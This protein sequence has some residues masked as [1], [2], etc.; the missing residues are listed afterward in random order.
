MP[1]LPGSN[2]SRRYSDMSASDELAAFLDS[3]FYEPLLAEGKFTSFKRIHDRDLQLKGV[4]V[5]LSTADLTVSI[6]EKAQLYYINKD[7]PTFAFELQFLNNGQPCTGWFLNETLLTNYYLL[8]WPKARVA[9]A[10]SVRKDDFI[11]LDAL[12]VSRKKLH[13]FLA[14]NGLS[15]KVLEAEADLLRSHALEYDPEERK[16]RT[17]L[18]GAYYYVSD[19][20]RYAEAPINLVIGK[21]HL[22]SI[23]SAHYRITENGFERL[24]R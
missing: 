19:P 22:L 8:I 7:L 16:I 15:R 12:M 2:K 14:W 11:E 18:G 9:R 23:A 24:P 10:G 6:D 20:Q 1:T 3:Y 21:R 5:E 4:D 17:A 13:D